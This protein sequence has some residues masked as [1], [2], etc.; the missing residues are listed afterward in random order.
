MNVN[1]TKLKKCLIVAGGD[2]NQAET[3]IIMAKTA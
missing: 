1:Y 2:Q 3:V